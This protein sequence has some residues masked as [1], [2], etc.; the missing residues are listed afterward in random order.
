LKKSL[1]SLIKSQNTDDFRNLILIAFAFFTWGIGE[2]I[3]F[4][5]QPIYLEE[6]GATPLFIGTILGLNGLAMTLVQAPSGYLA[7]RLGNR[8]VMRLAWGIGTFST[9]IMAFTHTLIGFSIGWILYGVSAMSAATSSYI[10][11]VRGTLSV[12]RALTVVSA[13]YHLGA[14]LGPMLGGQIGE[15]LGLQFI[16]RFALGFFVCSSIILAFAGKD[17]GM[18][19]DRQKP[20]PNLLK[21]RPFVLLLG[22]S[23]ISIFSGYLAEPLTPNYLQDIHQLSLMDIGKLGSIG[24]LGNAI[25]SL[26]F[27]GS[28]PFFGIMLGHSF[29]ALFALLIWQGRGMVWFAFAFFMRGGYRIFQAMYLSIGRSILSSND[30]GF[31]Y[32]LMATANSMA[33]ILAPP[34]A[35]FLYGI[36]PGLIYPI[37]LTMLAVTFI[38]NFL[39][40]KHYTQKSGLIIGKEYES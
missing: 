27:G 19:L 15:N 20:I 24:S 23:F 18:K 8:F 6:L 2:G 11:N 37:S 13:T 17:K 30:M 4:Y 7:D 35:G 3:F 14:F 28:S 31:A 26:A 34:V 40:S 21:F 38:L 10:T 16:Y 12:G 9:I 22:V 33:I 5:F 39:L 1:N 36:S 32:G 25:I 29:L